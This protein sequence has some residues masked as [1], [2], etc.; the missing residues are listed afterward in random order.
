M[1]A[2][3][4]CQPYAEMIVRGRKVIENRTWPTYYRGS[5]YIHAGKSRAWFDDDE[6]L[7]REFG[8]L[9]PFGAV[10]AIADL[11]DCRRVGDLPPE[12][13]NNEHANGPWCWLLRNITPIG[14][15]PC[16]GAQGL[17]D[18]DLEEIANRE[19]GITADG[20]GQHG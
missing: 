11:Y 5:M 9:P 8:R 16:R 7:I 18:I 6:Q 12:L 20:G 3:T 2:L 14:P 10:V 13:E 15:W 17:F 4:I 1:K 19:L